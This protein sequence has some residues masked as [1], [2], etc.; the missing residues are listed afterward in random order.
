VPRNRDGVYQEDCETEGNKQSKIVGIKKLRFT[1]KEMFKLGNNQQ[2]EAEKGGDAK[3]KK[4]KDP[5]GSNRG[6]GHLTIK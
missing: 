4:K 5:N 2:A 3:A 6:R 1:R